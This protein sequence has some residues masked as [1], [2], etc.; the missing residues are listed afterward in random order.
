VNHFKI[1]IWDRLCFCWRDAA[2]GYRRT[3]AT[4]EE[5]RAFCK[6]TGRYRISRVTDAGR[7]DGDPFDVA[8]AAA[9]TAKP[10]A[11]PRL[12]TRPRPRLF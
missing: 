1:A 7:A 8:G 6:T 11:R 10:A 2:P 9:P 4:E 12:A 3:F 5:A